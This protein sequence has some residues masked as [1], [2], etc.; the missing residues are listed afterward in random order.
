MRLFEL[1]DLV[2]MDCD[3]E[4]RRRHR[5][6]R[7]LQL[8]WQEGR[9]AALSS[10]APREFAI[11]SAGYTFVWRGYIG[12]SDMGTRIFRFRMNALRSD[13]IEIECAYQFKLVS[14]DLGLFLDG[15]VQ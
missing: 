14:A 5:R 8:H 12:A 2:I 13:R 4:Y 1:D 6:D 3:P 11:P 9:T 10:A 7:E 15:I